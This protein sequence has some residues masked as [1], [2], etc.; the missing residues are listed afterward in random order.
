MSILKV[1]P[2]KLIMKG[3]NEE[4][5]QAQKNPCS[6]FQK[7][8]H[9]ELLFKAEN[10]KA[11]F[12]ETRLRSLLAKQKF[13]KKAPSSSSKGE[14]KTVCHSDRR[15]DLQDEPIPLKQPLYSVRSQIPGSRVEPAKRT[16]NQSSKPQLDLSANLGKSKSKSKSVL[17]KSM[18]SKNRALVLSSDNIIPGPV[19]SKRPAADLTKFDRKV[20]ELL[21]RH[22]KNLGVY[23]LQ[24]EMR[25]SEILSKFQST[26]GDCRRATGGHRAGLLIE[27]EKLK[28]KLKFAEETAETQKKNTVELQQK[29]H[30]QDEYH[31]HL[32]VEHKRERD[33]LNQEI[34]SLS[35]QLERFGSKNSIRFH[36][37]SSSNLKEIPEEEDGPFESPTDLMNKLK[38]KKKK[39]SHSINDARARLREE[40]RRVEGQSPEKTGGISND[41]FE[42][43]PKKIAGD[44]LEL[45]KESFSLSAYLHSKASRH[46]P[47]FNSGNEGNPYQDNIPYND[48]SLYNDGNG[49]SD[50]NPYNDSNP[51]SDSNGYNESSPYNHSNPYTKGSPYSQELDHFSRPQQNSANFVYQE[52][53]S[54]ESQQ[55]SNPYVGLAAYRPAKEISAYAAAQERNDNDD[56]YLQLA[57][58]SQAPGKN[59]RSMMRAELDSMVERSSESIISKQ[60]N[61]KITPPIK[62]VLA[63]KFFTFR[64]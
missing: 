47:S 35:A 63:E 57:A 17:S 54:S 29:L 25:C 19:N 34:A 40:G 7:A 33:K 18:I 53:L 32:I 56:C 51:Y 14:E 8:K 50:N 13:V 9:Y 31:L 52:D 20:R 28:K 58:K 21:E 30:R 55:S 4:S 46:D 10:E 36:L 49:Y 2:I 44:P 64:Q 38:E 62:K 15:Q 37:N 11:K 43:G 26:L 61:P 5:L 45:S 6:D 48:N 41:T 22:R 42:F 16:R 12:L 60:D 3:P 1:G 59:L 27:L 24:I 23:L 39:V